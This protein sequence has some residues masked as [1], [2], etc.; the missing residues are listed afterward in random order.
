M[1]RPKGLCA[2]VGVDG[3]AMNPDD[4]FLLCFRVKGVRGQPKPRRV[5][6]LA[7]HNEF[8]GESLTAR[9]ERELCLPTL[10]MGP[11]SA[12]RRWRTPRTTDRSRRAR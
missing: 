4:P 8:G 10:L 3:Q 12:L 5:V 11:S 6:G 1:R 9:R 2:P 7:V